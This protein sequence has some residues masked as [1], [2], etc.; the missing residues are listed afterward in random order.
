VPTRV[1]FSINKSIIC[2]LF[3]FVDYAKTI[4]SLDSD[5]LSKQ[6]CVSLDQKS[7]IFCGLFINNEHKFR[8]LGVST[9]GLIIWLRFRGLVA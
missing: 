5:S 6:K 4:F 2:V 9:L 3:L 7:A 8:V 1:P